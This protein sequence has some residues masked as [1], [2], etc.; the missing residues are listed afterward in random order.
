MSR[1]VCVRLVQGNGLDLSLFQFDYDL[2]FGVFFL[3]ADRTIYG[4]YGTRSHNTDAT[5]DISLAGFAKAMEAALELHQNHPANK[6]ALAGKT[7][8][9]PRYKAPEEFPSLQGKFT[10]SVDFEGKPV[11]SCIHCH[12]VREAQRKIFRDARQPLPDELLFPWP[13]PDVVGLNLDPGEKAKIKSVARGSR[14]EKDGF[15]AGDE[16]L[17][18]N[19]QPILSIADVQWVM[20]TAK[21][22]AK[23]NAQVRRAGET[24]GLTLTLDRGWRRTSDIAWRPTSWELRRMAFGGMKLDAMSAEEKAK[25]R[26]AP[27]QMALRIAHVGQ[28]GDHALAK[29]AGFLKD[30]IVLAVDGRTQPMTES[31]LF[32]HIL[33]TK[34]VGAQVPAT[35]LRGNQRME[36]QI[37]TQ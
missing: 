36:M 26:I 16:I 32:A 35:I 28:Y 18:L 15:K 8:P 37:P 2:T 33:Q 11:A 4:R 19:G 12:Q 29:K 23:I 9:A 25:L 13:M 1:F 27:N 17:T 24:V 21:E 31:E 3:N 10:S 34:P 6:A 30:D 22:P 14:A 7:G 5:R 20:H